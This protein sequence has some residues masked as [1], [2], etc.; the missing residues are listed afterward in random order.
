VEARDHALHV[1]EDRVFPLHHR[2]WRQAALALAQ[3]HRAA[4]RVE[5][6]PDI[7]RGR[8]RVLQPAAI[9]EDVVVVGGGGA[10]GQHQLRHRRHRGDA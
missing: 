9:G 6:Q 8:D 3:A 10:A 4:G 5:A 7:L 2:I 1:G